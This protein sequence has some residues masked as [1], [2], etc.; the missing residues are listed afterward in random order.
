MHKGLNE[1]RIAKGREYLGNTDANLHEK[2]WREQLTVRKKHW[3]FSKS[4]MNNTQGKRINT[5]K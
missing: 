4:D 5:R 1:S 3:P 2:Q